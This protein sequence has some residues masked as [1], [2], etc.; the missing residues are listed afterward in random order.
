MESHATAVLLVPCRAE[1]AGRAASLILGV[2]TEAVHH[3]A[4]VVDQV[5][6]GLAGAEVDAATV[7]AAS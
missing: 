4:A 1:P 7:V 3:G 2:I 5:L 6:D